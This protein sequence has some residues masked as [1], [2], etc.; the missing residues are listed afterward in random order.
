MGRP[1]RAPRDDDVGDVSRVH[2]FP[3]RDKRNLSRRAAGFAGFS[4]LAGWTGLGAGGWL[5]R[6]DAVLAMSPPLTMGVTG[7]L[8]AWAH[9]APL[10]FNIQ[11]VFPDAAVETGAI[12]NRRVIAVAG[13][14]E[15]LS[16]RLADAVTVL[17]DDLRANVVGEGADGATVDT[18]PNFVDTDLIRPADRMTPY[19]AEL[20]IGDEP[21]VLYAGNVGFSQSLDLLVETARRCPDVTVLINGDGAA[22]A[23]LERQAAGIA[24]V[25][26]AG[27]VPES[28]LERA[29]GDGRHP[30]RAAAPGLGRVSVPSKVYSIL[31]AGR[32]VVAA[33]DEGTEV[34]RSARGVRRGRSPCRPTT[35]TASS[36]PSDASPATR[37][38]RAR[39]GRDGRAWVLGAASP[40]AVATAYESLITALRDSGRPRGHRRD[41]AG[42]IAPSWF[43]HRRRRRP[44][45]WPRRARARRSAS[46]AGPCSRWSSWAS[47]CSAWRPSSTPAPASRRPTPRR[48][49]SATTGTSPTASRCATSRSSSS[50]TGPSRR[51]TASG[52]LIN[53]DF[54][55]T[56]V[57]SHD[58]GVIHWHAS[59]S[60][61]TGKNATLGLFLDNYGVELDDDS[62]KFPENQGG[63]EYVEGE[64]ECPD[65]EDGELTVTVWDSPEDTSDGT[66]LRVRLRRHPHRQEQPRDHDRLP[67]ARHRHRDA[68]V[69]RR[70]RAARR[71]RHGPDRPTACPT[72]RCP[73]VR[74]SPPARPSPASR[75]RTRRRRRRAARRP[76]PAATTTTTRLM[77][78][79]VLVGGFGTRL[80]PLTNVVPK[81]MLPVAHVP[82]IVR[83]IG[84]LERGG[85]DAVTLALGFLPEPF[86]E[87]FPDGRCGGVDARL[88]DRA[89][90]ARH[91]RGDPLRRRTRRHRRDV[92]R[93]QRRRPHR[94]GDRRPRRRAPRAPA[95]R[96]RSTSRPVD[97]PS[98]FGVAEVD[99]GGPHSSASSRSRRPGPAPSN[100]INAGTYV[101]EPS[102]LERI[103]AG[104]PGVDRA[105]RLPAASP[106]PGASTPWP[107]TTTGSTPV[108]PSCTSRPTSTSCPAGATRSALPS[109][110]GR[111]STRRR[112]SSTAWSA[113]G[114]RSAPAPS[115]T[116]SVV[117]PGAQIGAGATVEASIVAGSVG[118]RSR[119]VRTVVGADGKIADGEQYVDA[120][121]PAAD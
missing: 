67:A 66:P 64:T 115:V 105:R 70:A 121:V 101:F 14:L 53:T 111:S 19:R 63:K 3:G 90:A 84:Q 47:W 83:L 99:A 108:A 46:R 120:R 79:V 26:F 73:T 25:R 60:A 42:S 81:S 31:A 49:R 110:T 51:P 93:R 112:P 55:R 107:P 65:G 32:P 38:W 29:A 94:P 2:P 77:Q 6:A 58:D 41:A 39:M 96:R 85:V 16:Y 91:R 20:G 18:I 78:A 23:E 74:R 50:S 37:S 4:A 114:R 52:Q 21:V 45:G 15:R 75:R 86:V 35:R 12:T 82:L 36:T 9:R 54:L 1:P 88:R 28:R 8:V 43:P 34:P 62:L 13:W 44:P 11:D 57:H 116:G 24:N 71:G 119:L 56:G 69:G 59:T 22:R 98:A 117:L 40:A 48:R 118:P 76:P 80:R 89:G 68:A 27:Y 92:R 102:V 113:T 104:R 61:A 100:L 72:V 30:R 103:P 95:P 87:A 7:R 33:I 109:R 106:P 5:R 17:S 10:V 97:D